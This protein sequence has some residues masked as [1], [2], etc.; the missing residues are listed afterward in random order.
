MSHPRPPRYLDVRT[1]TEF[2]ACH[3]P[4]SVNVPLDR[5][6]DFAGKLAADGSGPL[7]LVCRTGRR[8]TEAAR[9]LECSGVAGGTPLEGGIEAWEA[10]GGAVERGR[11]ALSMERQVRIAAGLLAATGSLL[12][13]T[14]N[15]RFALVPLFVGS[16]LTFAG[17]TDTCG[18]A[19][20][21]ARLPWNRRGPVCL[22]T[23]RRR[24]AAR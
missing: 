20:L 17:V 21:L 10:A 14:V 19:L 15:P 13:L 1:P 2:E 7:T 6:P 24:L 8:A 4:G 12:A 5:L 16:G 22:A 23:A 9:V 11:P 18:M 3:I